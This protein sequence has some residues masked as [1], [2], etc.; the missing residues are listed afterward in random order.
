MAEF[1]YTLLALWGIGTI[2]TICLAIHWIKR[3]IRRG[4]VPQPSDRNRAWPLLLG[5][6]VFSFGLLWPVSWTLGLAMWSG[7]E[8]V[9]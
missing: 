3:E 7:G 1:W 6:F 8:P 4:R 9:D 5:V 2:V